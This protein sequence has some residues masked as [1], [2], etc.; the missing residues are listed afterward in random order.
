MNLAAELS[1]CIY[2]LNLEALDSET[3]SQAKVLIVDALAC[4]IAGADSQ[5]AQIARTVAPEH[6]S[7]NLLATT[8]VTGLRTSASSAALINGAM[9]RA[10]DLMDVYVGMD[11]CHPSEIIPAALACAEAA[12]VS[13]KA[14]LEATIAGLALHVQIANSIPL[15]RHGLHHVGQAAW[16]VPLIASRLFGHDEAS[17]ARALTICA[18][19]MIVPENFALGQLTNLKALAY[20]LIARRCIDIVGLA[21]AG[22]TGSPQACD[23]MLLLL[24]SKF[25]MDIVYENLVSANGLDL[26]GISLKIYP[27]Q[28]ALQPLI[29]TAASAQADY[30]RLLDQLSHI[31]VRVSQRTAERTADPSKFAPSTPEAADHSLPFCVAIALLDGG[32]TAGALEKGRWRDTDVLELMGRIR[33]KTIDNSDDYQVGLQDISL[34][35]KSGATRTFECRYPPEYASWRTIAEQ[36]L[37]A[38]CGDKLDAGRILDIVTHIEQEQNLGRLIAALTQAAAQP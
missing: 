36:K 30:R 14:F 10:L 11:V 35:L 2:R 17:A 12:K 28:Y 24:A 31:V 15:H 6:S 5:G 32:L 3:I 33:V 9:L 23:D 18:H 29:V 38:A 22:L 25:E 19:G 4:A 13:G 27:A 20:P 16:V 7:D 21:A 37:H 8:L 1:G 34:M 26:S